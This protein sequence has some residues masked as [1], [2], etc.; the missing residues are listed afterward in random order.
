MTRSPS[1][2]Y[3][4]A[5]VRGSSD[6]R[7]VVVSNATGNRTSRAPILPS[8]RRYTQMCARA[9]YLSSRPIGRELRILLG[10]LPR[11][12]PNLGQRKRQGSQITMGMTRSVQ[13]R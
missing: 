7:P 5:V 12:I 11:M 2:R 10:I 13:D 6:F 1:R 9:K 4:V 3:R 8:V